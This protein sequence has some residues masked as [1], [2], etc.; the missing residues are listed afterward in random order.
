MSCR[1]ALGIGVKPG[2]GSATGGGSHTRNLDTLPHVLLCQ[3]TVTLGFC[4][5]FS[6]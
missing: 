3:D 5:P 1:H 2:Q 4:F 6:Q